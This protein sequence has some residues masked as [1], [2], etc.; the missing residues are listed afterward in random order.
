MLRN[1]E[2]EQYLTILWRVKK[3]KKTLVV[4][5][6]LGESFV[7]LDGFIN[8]YAVVTAQFTRHPGGFVQIKPFL[9]QKCVDMISDG[10]KDKDDFR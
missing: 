7:W 5:P 1:N 8:N 3:S 9:S 6:N 10:P 2:Q 4:F